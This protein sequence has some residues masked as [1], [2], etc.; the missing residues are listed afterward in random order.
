MIS[1]ASDVKFG[2]SILDFLLT[3]L[4]ADMEKELLKGSGSR[5][6]EIEEGLLNGMFGH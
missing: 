1:C 5:G 2:V 4:V 3:S 6:V